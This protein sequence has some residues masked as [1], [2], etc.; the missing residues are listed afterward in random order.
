MG[1]YR[2]VDTRLW[3][4]EKF[5]SLPDLAKLLFLFLLT[6]PHMTSIGAMR[7]SCVGLAAE[8][9][10]GE[11]V[12]REAFREVSGKGMAKVDEKASCLLLPNFL[13]YNRPESPNV[14]KSW[15]GCIDL[16]PECTLKTETVQ[17]VKGFLESLSEDF[18]KAL[19]KGFAEA[20]GKPSANSEQEQELEQEQEQEMD[21]GPPSAPRASPEMTPQEF[22]ES[23]N[24]ICASEGLPAV[25]DLSNGRRKKIATRLRSYPT[26]AFWEQVFNGVNRSDFLSGRK[27]NPKHPNWR[28]TIDWLIENDENPLKVIEGAYA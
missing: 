8:L 14:V 13:K 2:K 21:G 25:K 22:I 4:D 12:F 28:A 27:P 19:P 26:V 11:K 23:W 7:C 9:G 3:N 18:V 20:F 24:E 17:R 6:H 10:W 5:R 16:I 15:L 1:H